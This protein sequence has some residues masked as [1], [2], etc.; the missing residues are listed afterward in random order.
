MPNEMSKSLQNNPPAL[1]HVNSHEE[2]AVSA[3]VFELVSLLGSVHL[4]VAGLAKSA[5]IEA[6]V[7]VL[8]GGGKLCA[9]LGM[10][11]ATAHVQSI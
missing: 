5:G 3:E 7:S 4:E 1:S 2:G 8:A 6:A 11:T 9:P 10:V